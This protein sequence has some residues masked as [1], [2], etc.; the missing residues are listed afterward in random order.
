MTSR[1]D[2]LIIAHRGASAD[3][4]ENTR[5]AFTGAAEQ[6]SDWVE[7]DVRLASD[8]SLIV[9]H[10]A[11]YHDQR[12]VWETPSAQ[13]PPEVPDLT[14]ALQA[15]ARGAIARGG[16][17]MGVNVE[18]KNTPGD[19]GGDDVPW[20]LDVVEPVL[21]VLAQHRSV[22]GLGDVLLTSFDAPTVDRVRELGGPPTGQLVAD[23]EGW[24]DVV[25]STADR[26]H[27]AVNPWDPFV[28]AA[29]VQRCHDHALAANVWTVDAHDRII[30]LADMGV[31]GIV[32][33][34][35]ASARR[36]LQA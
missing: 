5:D 1:E 20:S 32:T 25:E 23:V 16:T 35:P 34:V 17:P 14:Q 27:V 26:G 10:D 11:W 18:I 4:A 30:E 12:T 9:N 31:D 6:G 22:E 28:D 15:C 8:G 13:R 24:P 36:A 29:F 33:N 3:Y 19:L 2:V 21:E 7:L